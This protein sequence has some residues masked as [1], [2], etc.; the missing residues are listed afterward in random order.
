[1][2]LSSRQ[3]IF[4]LFSFSEFRTATLFDFP[5]FPSP[6]PLPVQAVRS[7]P[8]FLRGGLLFGVTQPLRRRQYFSR[9]AGCRIA[10]ILAL[11]AGPFLHVFYFL[12][13]H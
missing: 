7:S 8:C 3:S 5:P 2:F 13:P 4:S 9:F 12:T 6:F 1:M 10:L 11:R